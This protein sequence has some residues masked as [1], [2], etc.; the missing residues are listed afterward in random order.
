MI[1]KFFCAFREKNL[2][3][4]RRI[5]SARHAERKSAPGSVLAR[6]FDSSG[7]NSV[8]RIIMNRNNHRKI[9]NFFGKEQAIYQGRLDSSS[10]FF[11]L[12]LKKNQA[13]PG[14]R[15]V[16]SFGKAQAIYQGGL[17]SSVLPPFTNGAV[18]PP[19]G[20]TQR[21]PRTGS[22]RSLG[23][24]RRRRSCARSRCRRPGAG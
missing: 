4:M 19:N 24:S 23:P 2:Y 6:A 5:R 9:L 20:K 14:K 22:G 18:T 16:F 8:P 17:D 7:T 21:F 11:F 13:P 1:V 15:R 10:A 3:A 12:L